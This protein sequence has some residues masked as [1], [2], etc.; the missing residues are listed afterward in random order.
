MNDRAIE[1]LTDA[2]AKQIAVT[3]D[4]I[5]Q[6]Q[7]AFDARV[8][9]LESQGH[10]ITDGGQIDRNRWEYT[11][12]R[13]DEV[14]ANGRCKDHD[15][16]EL[17]DNWYHV[18]HIHRETGVQ[19]EL[20]EGLPKSLSDLLVYWTFDHEDEARALAARATGAAP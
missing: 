15:K 8:Q 12:W 4:A 17:P 14:L 9:E 3:L 16:V 1:N 19:P 18:D 2:V 11:D 6:D 5:D 10:R 20:V 13:T 7:R